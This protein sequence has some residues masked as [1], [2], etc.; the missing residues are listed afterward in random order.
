MS[1]V[2]NHIKIDHVTEV[3]ECAKC[4]FC[5]G[6]VY[7]LRLHMH[8]K[9]SRYEITCRHCDFLVNMERDVM[10]RWRNMHVST[11][12]GCGKCE[13]VF[14]SSFSFNAH[15]KSV[16]ETY[17]QSPSFCKGCG[18]AS[19]RNNSYKTHIHRKHVRLKCSCYWWCWD[20][21]FQ[22]LKSESNFEIARL[23]CLF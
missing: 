16:L 23:C 11:P 15:D 10:E 4:R 14:D 22:L 3:S 18:F 6:K 8:R 17:R 1:I 21:H 2:E 19:S 9:H 5:Q 7:L 12:F 13:Y 20:I